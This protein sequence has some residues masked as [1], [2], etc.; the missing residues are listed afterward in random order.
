MC[1]IVHL[2]FLFYA[3][4]GLVLILNDLWAEFLTGSVIFTTSVTL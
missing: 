2:S 1:P 4:L 3:S